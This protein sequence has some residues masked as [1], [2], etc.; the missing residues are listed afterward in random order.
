M[1]VDESFL[2]KL[3]DLPPE[4]Q[5]EAIDFVEFLHNKT[6][7]AKSTRQS[8]KGLWADL[9]IDITEQEITS[10]RIECWGSFPRESI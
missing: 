6:V 9:G 1:S 3:R 4:K 10:A 2:Q 7:V 5:R 8:I